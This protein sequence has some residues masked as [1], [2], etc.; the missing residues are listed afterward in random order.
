MTTTSTMQKNQAGA[1]ELPAF[2]AISPVQGAG[3]INI[4]TV[5]EL[6]DELP[7][8]REEYAASVEGGAGFSKADLGLRSLQVLAQLLDS[9]LAEADYRQAVAAAAAISEKAFEKGLAAARAAMAVYKKSW[10]E[11]AAM[12]ELAGSQAGPFGLAN[13][14]A[15][16][17]RKD[18]A[19][20]EKL[21]AQIPKATSFDQSKLAQA[22]VVPD[23][24]GSESMLRAMG[25]EALLRRATLVT[26]F[27]DVSLEAAQK[28]LAVG[29]KYGGLRGADEWH[30]TTIVTGNHLQLAD[31][32]TLSPAP[33]LAGLLLRNGSSSG[34]SIAVTPAGYDHP[35]EVSWSDGAR[36]KW[37][38][39]DA[40]V[41]AA[42]REAIVPLVHF[43]ERVCFWGSRSLS[44]AETGEAHFSVYR[45]QQFLQK[46]LAD[47]LNR[48]CFKVIG[49]VQAKQIH[50]A[51]AELLRNCAG[52]TDEYLLHAGR[53]ISVTPSPEGPETCDVKLELTFK[54]P[55]GRFRVTSVVLKAR[56][57][58][59]GGTDVQSE[60]TS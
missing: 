43:K 30:K 59:G 24:P 45:T 23:W 51:V 12:T 14:S 46:A 2:Q 26:A 13:C 32:T 39:D 16:R 42:F 21:L 19:S 56:P 28:A 17:L 20:R 52:G 9:E 31:G 40:A 3:V 29:G 47:F 18:E 55:T 41:S 37:A 7:A 22:I 57:A 5:E 38:I 50:G 58:D 36:L 11:F 48:M 27:P 4:P 8:E 10:L 44:T 34:T 15:D 1:I 53:V 35:V 6:L 25:V 49:P 33:L 60:P 54:V